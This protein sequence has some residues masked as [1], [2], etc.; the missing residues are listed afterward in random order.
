MSFAFKRSFRAILVTSTTTAV[1]FAANALSDIRPIRAFGI[2]A[3]ILIP[4][5]FLILILVLPSMQIIHD[6]KFKERCDY[7]KM[8]CS[9]CRKRKVNFVSDQQVDGPAKQKDCMNRFFST[10]HNRIIYKLRY[11]LSVFF[12]VLGVTAAVIASRIGSLTKQED[13]IPPSDPYIV[14]QT[15]VEDNFI[16]LGTFSAAANVRG[17]IFVNVNWG[18]KDLDRSKVDLWDAANMGE[19]VWDDQFTVAP[20]ENQ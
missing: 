7:K 5:N 4:M 3:A 1:A 19:L 13:Y 8:L 6:R 14:L 17:A 10:T 15:E 20:K 9:R 12:I 18:V 11:L 2:F 16:Q